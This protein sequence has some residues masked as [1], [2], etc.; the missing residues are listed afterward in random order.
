MK[1][2]IKAALCLVL[3]LVHVGMEFYPAWKVLVK[4]HLAEIDFEKIIS[5]QEVTK[6]VSFLTAEEKKKV[7]LLL[8]DLYTNQTK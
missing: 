2:F 6:N 7:V 8:E 3:I 1:K 4:R 5:K